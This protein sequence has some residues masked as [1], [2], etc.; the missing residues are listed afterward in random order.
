MKAEYEFIGVYNEKMSVWYW[1][2]NNS[3]VDKNLTKISK[4]IC[5]YTQIIKDNYRSYD[6]KEAEQYYYFCN[7]GNFYLSQENIEKL[8]KFTLWLKKGIWF[9]PISHNNDGIVKT[10][11]IFIKNITYIS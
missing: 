2:W 8:I 9:Y 4:D 3:F 11:Y 1:A 10:E 5:D 6:I 7:N